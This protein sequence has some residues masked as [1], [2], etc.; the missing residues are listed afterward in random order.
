MDL[1]RDLRGEVE[2][3]AA[4][5]LGRRVIALDESRV[6]L[7]SN[8]YLGQ[9]RDPELIEA[10]RSACAE[11]G[12][13]G[14]AARLLGG[15]APCDRAAERAAA[16]WLGAEDALL[17]PSGYQANLGLV[18]ALVRRGD[19]LL[20]DRRNHASLIDGARLS[21]ATVRVF[22]DPDQLEDLL[23]AGRGA[24]RRLV[25]TEGVFSMDGDSPDL[26]DLAARCLRHGAHLVVDEAHGAGLVGPSGAG[27]WAAA[28]A[29]PEALAGRVLTGGKALGAAG[30][31]IV[32]SRALRELCLHRARSFVFTTAVAP[33]VAAALERGIARARVADEARGR[34]CALALELA[35]ALDLPRPDAAIVPVPVGDDRRALDSAVALAERGFEVRA[36]RP[37][38]VPPGTARLRIVTHA[39][40]S[41]KQIAELVRA[42][43][44]LG[45]PRPAMA[46]AAPVGRALVVVGT[47]TGVGKTVASAALVHA[48]AGRGPVGYWKP[49]QTGDDDDTTTVRALCEGLAV[50][51]EAPAFAFPAPASPHEAAAA[52][53]RSVDVQELDVRLAALHNQPGPTIVELA[54]GLHVPLTDDVLQADW[55]ARHRPEVVLV[56]RSGLGTLN[57]T[58]LTVEALSARGMRPK[59]L[60]LVGEPHRSNRETLARRTGLTV[61]ELPQLEPLTPDSLG[62][63]VATQDLLHG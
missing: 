44:D 21:R 49:V 17:F 61:V 54:G 52:V 12:A 22:D 24:R 4:A 63:W 18:G 55:L 36:V 8:D 62:A 2:A 60:V 46:T 59:L 14:R 37:P 58:Q 31:L 48:A 51:F 47:D 56:A 13:G 9:A 30:G 5:G 3:L 39:F 34:A 23:R 29:P 16:D 53:G 43:E 1:D 40:N 45:L 7:V 38:T 11:F 35:L 20:S 15:G 19:L 57:H 25:V 32:G 41:S 27:A 26:A 33:A 10:A 42:L 28:D 6:D 50:R